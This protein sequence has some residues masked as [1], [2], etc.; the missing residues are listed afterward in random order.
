MR[1][2]HVQIND[3]V[4]DI[5]VEVESKHRHF[6]VKVSVTVDDNNYCI[7]GIPLFQGYEDERERIRRC[8]I[9]HIA[10]AFK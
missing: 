10:E 5:R 2:S 7:T 1:V 4:E 3:S 6:P 9:G 8:A